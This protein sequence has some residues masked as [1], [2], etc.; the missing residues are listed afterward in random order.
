MMNRLILLLSCCAVLTVALLAASL[1]VRL[2]DPAAG[3][4]KVSHPA[5]SAPVLSQI[6][7]RAHVL[8][9]DSIAVAG[10]PIR[11]F[12]IDAPEWR[13]RCRGADNQLYRCGRLA[14]R[15]LARRLQFASV[16]CIPRTR[17]RFARVV[18][19]CYQG[20]DDIARFM[21]RRG[22]A[23]DWPRYSGGEYAEAE[24]EARSAERG[25]WQGAFATPWDWRH[26]RAMLTSRP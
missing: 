7:G 2:P 3:R 25:L 12:G 18:A 19:T 8:D 23:L 1:S 20:E 4:S 16:R 21:V 22:L 13:Q 26:G 14:S 17:D 6:V 11:I 10:V 5:P 24:S 15:A 9:G